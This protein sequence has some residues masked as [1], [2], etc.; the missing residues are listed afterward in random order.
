MLFNESFIKGDCMSI[1]SKEADARTAFIEAAIWHGTLDRANAL[2]AAH[3][4]LASSDNHTAAILGDDVAVRR[5]LAEDAGHATA[6]S[7]PY[8]GD[9]LVYLCL[10]KY[11]RL[12]KARSDGFLRAA[13]ALLDAGANPNSGFWTKGDFPEF[14]TALYGAAGVAHHA[15]M[16]RLLLERGADPNDEEVP[17]HSPES[18]DNDALK[19]LVESG[20]LTA[21]SLATMLLRKADWHD[22]E[23]IKYL[24][25][26]GADPNRMTRW[27]HTALHQAL[28][29]DNAL[30]IVEVMLDHG[31]DPMLPNCEDGASALV[32]AARRGRSDVLDLLENR[33]VSLEFHGVDRLIAGC[34]R[35][36]ESK[37]HALV[38]S[39]P[40]LLKEILALGSNL[41]AE[42]A[43][44]ANTEGVRILLDLGVDVRSL[45]EGDGYFD[46]AKDS[47]ALHVAAWKAWHK[48]VK[49]LIE[50]GAPINISD[51][52]GRTPLMLAVKAC[53]DSYWTYRRSPESVKAL[54]DAES[55][56]DRVAFPCGYAD[57]DE[58]LRLHRQ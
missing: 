18:Y 16:T 35:N 37:V 32:I 45:Y 26:H 36:D 23:G 1:P 11:L 40:Q 12:D 7:E 53:V 29:R 20:K 34:A 2:L 39:E 33:G 43:G 28:R 24:L 31:A 30:K 42:F 54:L 6:P 51:G 56:T 8:G 19:V 10:S 22:F 5:F 15:E 3:P 13:A 44:T 4:E 50:R 9:A 14:E 21:D 55:T 58:L 47:T 46:I 49:L 27:H 48:T 17:Y 41:L 52:K 57:V 25:E 38:Q